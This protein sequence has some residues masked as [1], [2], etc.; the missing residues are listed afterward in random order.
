MRFHDTAWQA[1]RIN[2]EPVVHRGNFNFPRIDIFDRVVR[3]VMAVAHLDR[4][5]AQRE[6]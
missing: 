1:L 2:G 6:R 5:T 3:P 4:L